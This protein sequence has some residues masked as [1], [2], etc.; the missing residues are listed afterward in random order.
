MNK[1]STQPL[2]GSLQP[3]LQPKD[4]WIHCASDE[5]QIGTNYIQIFCDPFSKQIHL[6]K[7]ALKPDAPT[8]AKLFIKHVFKLHGL[9]RVFVSDRDSRVM[10]SFWKTIMDILGTQMRTATTKHPQSDGLSERSIRT[11]KQLLSACYDQNEDTDLDLLLSIVEFTY[12]DTIHTSTGV[13]PFMIIYGNTPQTPLSLLSQSSVELKNPRAEDF[14]NRM[15]ALRFMVSDKL[16]HLR[17]QML[18]NSKFMNTAFETDDLVMVHR[19]L[20]KSIQVDSNTPLKL[21]PIY[22]GPFKVLRKMA[23]NAYEIDLPPTFLGHRVI[24]QQYLKLFRGTNTPTT[25]LEKRPTSIPKKILAKRRN[26]LSQIEYLISW[27]DDENPS[28]QT[29]INRDIL[30]KLD[31]SL[32]ENYESSNTKIQ[33]PLRSLS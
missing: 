31:P 23:T 28:D 1:A 24:N 16:F 13:S 25:S 21:Q 6:V 18:Y 30:I 8:L 5:T 27:N 19:D 22:Y 11:I 3:L 29:W 14:F 17:S 20:C 10:S 9:P 32:I 2:Q 4:I 12:N 33:I 15:K 7:S 26:K